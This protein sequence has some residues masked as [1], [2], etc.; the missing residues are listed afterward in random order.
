MNCATRFGLVLVANIGIVV[1]VLLPEVVT[2]RPVMAQTQADAANRAL[3]E[4]LKLLQTGDEKSLKQMLDEGVKLW[5][6]GDVESLTRCSSFLNLKGE[7]Q[8][9]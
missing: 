9:F 3:D 5:K 4:W 2:V 8:Y 6:K 1:G 7:T